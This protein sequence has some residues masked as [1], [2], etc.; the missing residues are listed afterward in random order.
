MLKMLTYILD[1]ENTKIVNTYNTSLFW[2]R[3][4]VMK[5]YVN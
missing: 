3:L 1:Y 2:T 4:D 5:F